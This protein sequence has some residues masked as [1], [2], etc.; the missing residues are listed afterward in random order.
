M[1]R[2]VRLMVAGGVVLVGGL[3]LAALVDF[4]SGPWLA[5]IALALLG[6]AGVFAGI[7]SELEP[8]AFAVG[9]E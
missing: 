8:G 7:A 2:F 1:E 9:E 3:W 5:G 6:R 4:G